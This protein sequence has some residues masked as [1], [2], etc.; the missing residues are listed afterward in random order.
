MLKAVACPKILCPRP[1][2]HEPEIE[3][4]RFILL[5]WFRKSF[6]RHRRPRSEDIA[7]DKAGVS[8]PNTHFGW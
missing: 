7:I 8:A 4:A 1:Q 3:A 2:C 5:A 6:T